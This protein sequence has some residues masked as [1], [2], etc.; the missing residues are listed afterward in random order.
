M[1]EAIKAAPAAGAPRAAERRAAPA[2]LEWRGCIAWAPVSCSLLAAGG[3]FCAVQVANAA[4]YVLPRAGSKA[5]A[6]TGSAGRPGS[7]AA[8]A[9][10]AATNPPLAPRNTNTARPSAMSAVAA[11]GPKPGGPV[12]RTT[13]TAS[14]GSAKSKAGAAAGGGGGAAGAHWGLGGAALHCAEYA[15]PAPSGSHKL[16]SGTAPHSAMR[17]RV[18]ALACAQTGFGLTASVQRGGMQRSHTMVRSRQAA[19]S[20]NTC[21]GGRGF[22]ER[23]QAEQRGAGGAHGGHVWRQ[24]G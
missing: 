5:P 10:R 22:C 14:A 20:A 19:A 24:R 4:L 11:A 13:S 21:R 3:V 9:P 6:R 7:S 8:A 12:R 1:Q 18:F 15:S 17:W 16:C 2:G 23:P